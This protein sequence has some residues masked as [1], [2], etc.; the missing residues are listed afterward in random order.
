MIYDMSIYMDKKDS[1]LL[2][3]T[4]KTEVGF[5]SEINKPISIVKPYDD[6]AIGEKVKECL[7][8][9]KNEPI[10]PIHHTN[11]SKK[12]YEIITGIK[13][14][15]K[16]SKDR[17]S[18]SVFLDTEIGYTIMPLVR[19]SDGSYR[20]SNRYPEIKLDLTASCNQIGKTVSDAFQDL[21]K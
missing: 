13:S 20:P 14:Y 3:P 6:L 17:L 11:Q 12:A 2:L 19:H 18:I 5:S 8:I 9:C 4:A 10:L 16:F 7:E 1:L 21:K 15:S